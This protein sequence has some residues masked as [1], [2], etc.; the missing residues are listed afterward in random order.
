M[1]SHLRLRILPTEV[2]TKTPIEGVYSFDAGNEGLEP[3]PSKPHKGPLEVLGFMDLRC[4]GLIKM[5]QMRQYKK[6]MFF[7]SKLTYL[8]FYIIND[9]QGYFKIID[10]MRRIFRGF[11][12]FK[13]SSH[14]IML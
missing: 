11:M 2:K 8:N 3:L 14:S 5:R 9:Q 1:P 4:L 10:D 6:N 7:V 13:Y 12:P